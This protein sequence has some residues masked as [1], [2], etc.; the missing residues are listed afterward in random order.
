M[1]PHRGLLRFFC[2]ERHA[3]PGRRGCGLIVQDDGI[4]LA[5][6]EMRHRRPNVANT[7]DKAEAWNE[8]KWPDNQGQ[9]PTNGPG[10][11]SEKHARL[12]RRTLNSTI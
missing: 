7:T 4:A 8:G 6:D 11:L 1:K 10:A 2:G 12:F 3:T 9:L 5:E